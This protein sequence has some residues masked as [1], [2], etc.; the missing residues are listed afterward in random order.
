MDQDFCSQTCEV[1]VELSSEDWERLP[2]PA[3]QQS[4][5][6]DLLDTVWNHWGGATRHSWD[7]VNHSMHHALCLAIGSG[8]RFGP[9]DFAEIERRYRFGYWGHEDPGGFAEGFYTLAV[10]EGNLSAA[11]AFE[12]WKGRPPFIWD[13]VLLPRAG[14]YT[15][16][17]GWREVARLTVRSE[18]AWQ[19]QRVKVTSFAADGRYLVACSYRKDSVQEE[20]CASCGHRTYH[21]RR[22]KIDKRYKIT[23]VDLRR[24]RQQH[25]ETAEAAVN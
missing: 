25:R 3:P 17:G 20:P 11:R 14:H 23:T 6:L 13:A 24:Q 19:G 4:P 7:R 10:V 1:P 21:Y 16:S 9:D 12:K 5:V 18:F 15:K 8:M 22:E 2:P